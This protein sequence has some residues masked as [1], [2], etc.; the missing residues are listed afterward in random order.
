MTEFDARAVAKEILSALDGA[1]LIEPPSSHHEGC[2]LDAG[3]GV[4]AEVIRLRRERREQ[5]VGRKIG[6]T[7]RNIWAQYNVYAPIWGHMFAH[8]VHFADDNSA[9]QSLQ[10]MV[11]PRIEPEIA[12]KLREAPQAGCVEPR[13]ILQSVEWVAR[14]FEIVDCHYADWKFTAPDS[15]ID[16]SHHAALI[17]GEP[18]AVDTRDLRQLT[19]ALATCRVTLSKNG[20]LV[21]TGIGGNA[22]GHPALALGF[23]ADVIAA[24]PQATPLAAGEIITTGTLTAAMPAARGE[25]W[26]TDT[27]GLPLPRLTVEFV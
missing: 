20:E 3:Y 10:S 17:V 15:V 18:L 26:H 19:A 2:D 12:F 11:A 23:L 24:Q 1:R 21:E 13:V 9:R 27:D 16:F 4:A 14:S 25:T 7:N 6:Y 8:T 5:P 22:L